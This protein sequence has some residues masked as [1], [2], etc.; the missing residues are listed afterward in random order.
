MHRTKINDKSFANESGGEISK[1]FILA[2]IPMYMYTVSQSMQNGV[3]V[4]LP[5]LSGLSFSVL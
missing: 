3:A 2:K 5:S 1:K 4:F